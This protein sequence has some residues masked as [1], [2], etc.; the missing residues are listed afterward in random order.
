MR[1][2]IFFN[3]LNEI[4]I[5]TIILEESFNTYK[6]TINDINVTVISYYY[7]SVINVIQIWMDIVADEDSLLY[8]CARLSWDFT[9]SDF[10]DAHNKLLSVIKNKNEYDPE[11]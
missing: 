6:T 10:D 5:E 4:T 8:S 11:I 7:L 3:I 2:K 1:K 9:N